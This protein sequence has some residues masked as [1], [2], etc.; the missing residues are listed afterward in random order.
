MAG[1]LKEQLYLQIQISASWSCEPIHIF[2]FNRLRQAWC[3]F[4]PATFDYR[5]N[6]LY[7]VECDI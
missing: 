2:S 5:D 4:T 1:V 6:G 7:S 3:G